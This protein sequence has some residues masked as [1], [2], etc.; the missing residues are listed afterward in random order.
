[1]LKRV[2]MTPPTGPKNDL[3]TKQILILT[4]FLVPLLV[5]G[6]YPSP[7]LGSAIKPTVDHAL[8]LLFPGGR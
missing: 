8:S 5:F 1:M 7:L 6:V 4:A 3:G 2:A